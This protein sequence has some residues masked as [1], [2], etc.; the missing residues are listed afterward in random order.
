MLDGWKKEDPPTM[1]KLPI[2]A[3]IPEY[4][5]GRSMEPDVCERRKAI[6]DL[7]LIA[8]YYL[9]RVGEYTC[10]TKRNNDKQTVQFRIQDVTFFKRN[11]EGR[12]KQMPCKASAEEIM[13][14]DS[15]TL[16]LLNQKNGAGQPR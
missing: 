13:E 8:F 3:N 11:K 4:L 9:L 14:A 7:T 2:E 16:K 15:C 6:A 12:L 10:R 5:V 1:K